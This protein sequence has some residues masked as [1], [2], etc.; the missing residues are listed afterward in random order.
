MSGRALRTQL[1]YDAVAAD[2]LARNA[3]RSVLRPH[4]ERFAAHVPRPGVVLDL[5]AGPCCDSAELR[6]LGLR[7][8][9]VDR[10]RGMLTVARERYPGPR[11]QAD[12]RRLPF[13]SGVAQGAWA[14]ASLLH[15]PRHELA[16]AL[17]GIREVLAPSGALFVSLKRGSGERWETERYG[18]EQ[19][20]WF[21]YF[22]EKEVDAALRCA[23]FEIIHAESRAGS[24]AQW[25]M[26]LCRVPSTA[27]VRAGGSA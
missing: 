25:L 19:P 21:T 24:T 6:A 27:R 12:L 26:R 18:A 23:G 13:A 20:R 17:A 14:S 15:L 22:S 8:L 4:I 5:G 10:S 9:S 11:V 2:F 3:D 7:V 1:T 16:P